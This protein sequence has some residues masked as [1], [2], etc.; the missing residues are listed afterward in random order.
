MNIAT[1]SNPG[2]AAFIAIPVIIMI[3]I[4]IIIIKH[5]DHGLLGETTA[6]DLPHLHFHRP[7]V[8]FLSAEEED[9]GRYADQKQTGPLIPRTVAALSVKRRIIVSTLSPRKNDLAPSLLRNS[10]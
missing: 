10:R 6:F 8:A 9:N 5:S 3:I 2:I 4:M 1:T 7:R